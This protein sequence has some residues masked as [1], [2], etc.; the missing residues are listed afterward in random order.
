MQL[1]TSVRVF[2]AECLHEKQQRF[3]GAEA[4]GDVLLRAEPVS[5]F[6][7]HGQTDAA[8]PAANGARHVAGLRPGAIEQEH[9]DF[10]WI[11]IGWRRIAGGVKN[12]ELSIR[13]ANGGG[14]E[15]AVVLP[16]VAAGGGNGALDEMA[17][18]RGF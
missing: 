5:A 9:L 11:V 7:G 12:P 17:G 2:E 13:L 6:S 18:G 15:Q 14:A 4:A 1:K 3:D 16:D 8:A 10:R